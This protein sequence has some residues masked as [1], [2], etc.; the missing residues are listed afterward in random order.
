MEGSATSY[1]GTNVW[2]GKSPENPAQFKGKSYGIISVGGVLYMWVA[3]VYEEGNWLHNTRLA[4]ST[5]HGATWQKASWAFTFS[6]G[7][8]VPTF[9]NFG[10][11]YAGA[12]DTYVYSYYINP[13][14]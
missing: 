12:R 14:C 3:L 9:L 6:D 11:D 13:K 1:N 8:T 5:D 7:L 10:K 4:W 2:G